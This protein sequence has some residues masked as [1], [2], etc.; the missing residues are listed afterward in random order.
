MRAPG[1]RTVH[2][3]DA[4][5]MQHRVDVRGSQL[6]WA[7]RL[8]RVPR[9]DH[10]IKQ[11]LFQLVLEATSERRKLNLAIH[12]GPEGPEPPECIIYCTQHGP[13]F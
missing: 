3:H 6:S 2:T 4:D 1:K 10:A 11:D 13:S 12:G 7:L 9:T 8:Q 5:A